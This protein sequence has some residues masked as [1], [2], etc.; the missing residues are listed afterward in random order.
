MDKERKEIIELTF[1]QLGLR[2]RKNLVEHL[3]LENAFES[4]LLSDISSVDYTKGHLGQ[5]DLQE[6][7]DNSI[8]CD[9][10]YI[11]SYLSKE[12]TIKVNGKVQC[13]T[14][15]RGS[16]K[17]IIERV[18]NAIKQTITKNFPD[19]YT[20]A[21]IIDTISLEVNKKGG[22][23]RETINSLEIEQNTLDRWKEYNSKDEA[24]AIV[25]IKIDVSALPITA[26]EEN[27]REF[28]NRLYYMGAA[29][30]S[31]DY[32]QDFSGTMQREKLMEYLIEEEFFEVQNYGGGGYKTGTILDNTDSVGNNVLTYILENEGKT[33]RIKAYDKIVC[34]IEAGEVRSRL[35]GHV[36]DFANSS[37]TH[38]KKVFSNP[39]VKNRGCVRLEATVYGAINFSKEAGRK[40]IKEA[41]SLFSGKQLFVIQPAIKRWENLIENVDR[42]FVIGDIPEKRIYIGWYANTKTKRIVGLN[43][44]CKNAN[45]EKWEDIV[46]WAIG[47][48]CFKNCPIFFTNIISTD[49][50]TIQLSLLRCFFKGNETK[51]ILAPCNL[52]TKVY[53]NPP[54]IEEYLPSTTICTFTWRTKKCQNILLRKSNYKIMEDFS[55]L[56]DKK[57]ST[58]STRNRLQRLE[59]LLYEEEKVLWEGRVNNYL[60]S[61]RI[62]QEKRKEELFIL[63]NS[64][65]N[66][67]KRLENSNLRYKIVSDC[68]SINATLKTIELE[69]T[70]WNL[71]G[72]RETGNTVIIALEKHGEKCKVFAT[73]SLINKLKEIE[74]T[75]E[76]KEDKFNRITYWFTPQD[77]FEDNSGEILIN[78]FCK[79]KFLNSNNVE[80]TWVPTYIQHPDPEF[81]AIFSEDCNERDLE[82]YNKKERECFIQ[83]ATCPK[84]KDAISSKDVE[85]G[86]YII[87]RIAE[88]L[89]AKQK[90]TYLFILPANEEGIPNCTEEIVVYGYF[91]EKEM[92]KYG[93]ME[94]LLKI[95]SPIFCKFGILAVNPSKKK[96]RKI[97]IVF[98]KF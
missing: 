21:N 44:D 53:S 97:N 8:F 18:Y 90:R 61:I 54:D 3:L 35:G 38:L 20:H 85:E 9:D 33:V 46:Y 94:E 25:I 14:G 4:N 7:Q 57:K 84:P 78:F 80:I 95:P 1:K 11:Y 13:T 91:I 52:P 87:N 92:E 82:E 75:F 59:E 47:D 89:F 15:A 39:D 43:I 86:T 6:L 56:K 41:I 66:L 40:L 77:F 83:K 32:T 63:R 17:D 16:G 30:Y 72:Y 23:V 81:D 96:H 51:T 29:L 76:C 58:L 64:I 48:F 19:V 37:N 2:N 67:E 93:G 36:A 55:I 34:N 24:F 79:R 27:F 49:K 28:R 42:C 62:K 26:I 22:I 60:E 65:K 50:E 69:T 73:P 68:L 10:I 98:N 74:K 70:Q 5:T 12:D 31:I 88:G 71:I 45:L